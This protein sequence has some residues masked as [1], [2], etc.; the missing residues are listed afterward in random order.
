MFLEGLS[1]M[2]MNGSMWRAMLGR[3]ARHMPLSH[4]QKY[5]SKLDR[6]MKVGIHGGA[7]E[8]MAPTCYWVEGKKERARQR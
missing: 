4:A 8:S 6:E 5:F 7:A 2:G 3:A 1:K